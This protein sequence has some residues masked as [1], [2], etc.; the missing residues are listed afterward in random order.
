MSDVDVLVSEKLVSL[1]RKAIESLSARHP[2]IF[3]VV[4]GYLSRKD[5]HV[6]LQVT[7]RQ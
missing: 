4:N 3:S 2:H 1:R 7:E 6:G 5:N